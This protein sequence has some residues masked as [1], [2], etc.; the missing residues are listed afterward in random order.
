MLLITGRER[1]G[2]ILIMF[3][4]ARA[5]LKKILLNNVI[6]ERKCTTAFPLCYN[7]VS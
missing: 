5:T 7:A 4:M 3:A 6:N 2:N 1:V